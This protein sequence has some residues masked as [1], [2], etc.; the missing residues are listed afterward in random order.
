MRKRE[1]VGRACGTQTID[2][3]HERYT[4]WLTLKDE[5]VDTMDRPLS[6]KVE[7][8]FNVRNWGAK[9]SFA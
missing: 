3:R 6:G 1:G 5:R 7:K 8:S 4:Q 9:P 2:N